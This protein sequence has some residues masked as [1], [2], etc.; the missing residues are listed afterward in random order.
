[1]GGFTN[2][3]NSGDNG[4]TAPNIPTPSFTDIE[5]QRVAGQKSAG[6]FTDLWVAFWTA[7]YDGLSKLIVF[8][9]SGMDDVLAFATKLVTTAQ[10]T[11]SVGFACGL[12]S[13]AGGRVTFSR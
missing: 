7:V 12:S 3:P 6:W 1:M 9:I 8:F 4:G 2:P 13:A 11:G 10:G 5:K